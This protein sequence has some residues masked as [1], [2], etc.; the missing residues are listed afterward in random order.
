MRLDNRRTAAIPFSTAED[1]REINE[2]IERRQAERRLIKTK[3]AN[4]CFIGQ[5]A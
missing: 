1:I 2:R 3:A 5:I 4:S